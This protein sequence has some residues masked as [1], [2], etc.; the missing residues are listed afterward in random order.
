MKSYF[1]LDLWTEW[2]C[3]IV[4]FDDKDEA[5]WDLW[6]AVTNHMV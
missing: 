4:N 1:S 2:V 3:K 6:M 5:E